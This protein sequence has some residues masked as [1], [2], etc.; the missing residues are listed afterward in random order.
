[1][2]GLG[3]LVGLWLF[4]LASIDLHVA[5]MYGLLVV[6]AGVAGLSRRR[7]IAATIGLGIGAALCAYWVLPSLFVPPG[8]GIGPEDLRKARLVAGSAI[9]TLDSRTKASFGFGQGAKAIERQLSGAPAGA[10]AMK[11]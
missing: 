5:G 9:A 8:S 10:G 7:A 4:G 11:N 3:A 2:V 6:S 1:M